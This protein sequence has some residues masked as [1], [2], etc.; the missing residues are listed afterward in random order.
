MLTRIRTLVACVCSSIDL[1]KEDRPQ[2][3]GENSGEPSRTGDTF[4]P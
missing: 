3:R 4:M 1:G 2:R